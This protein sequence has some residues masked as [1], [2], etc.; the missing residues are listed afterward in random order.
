MAFLAN[1]TVQRWS[2]RRVEI[3]YVLLL[4]SLLAGWFIAGHGGLPS[5]WAGRAGTTVLLTCPMFF[6]GMVFSTLLRSC[7][8]ISGVMSANLF[9]AMCGGL[10]E[11]NSMYFGIRSL[12]LMAVGL[13]LLAFF[14]GILRSQSTEQVLKVSTQSAP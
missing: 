1:Y 10:L 7:G 3:C 2:M 4:V 9:G 6:S 12:Y 13:Y 8:E 5:N 11:Y 14:W